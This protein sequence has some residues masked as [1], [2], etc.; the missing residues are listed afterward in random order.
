MK[1][2]VFRI[3]KISVRASGASED[4]G[5]CCKSEASVSGQPECVIHEEGEAISSIFLL[6]RAS[7]AFISRTL[8][9]I[10]SNDIGRDRP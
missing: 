1:K 4:V 5:S 6:A 2:F 8:S 3:S 10:L 7:V 9:P